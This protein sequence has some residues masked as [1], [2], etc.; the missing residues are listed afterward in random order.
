ML[1]QLLFRMNIKDTQCGAKIMHR[2]AVEKIHSS[3]RIADVA[4]DIN[5]L[6]SVKRC[7]Y[8]ILEHPTEWTDKIGSKIKLNKGSIGIIL[9]VLRLR[10]FYSPFYPW[11]RP[12]RPLEG[13][14][15]KQLRAPQPL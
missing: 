12:L 8:T 6:Y 5:L 7:G 11:L 1:V 4:F 2:E 10:L 15:Y 14:I 13:W 9:S 3:L